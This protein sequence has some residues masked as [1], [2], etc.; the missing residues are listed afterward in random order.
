M[1]ICNIKF[2]R[3]LAQFHSVRLN[4][5]VRNYDWSE[6]NGTCSRKKIS[7]MSTH[8]RHVALSPDE[9]R[10]REMRN[11]LKIAVNLISKFDSSLWALSWTTYISVILFDMNLHCSPSW[12]VKHKPV[13]TTIS[14]RTRGSCS[15]WYTVWFFVQKKT[16]ELFK[17][18]VALFRT[19]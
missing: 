11:Y 18:S 4:Q 3:N 19:S 12:G 7:C 14:H 5:T 9:F 16:S 15:R 8:Y 6:F 2:N 1:S 17:H 13:T 10:K